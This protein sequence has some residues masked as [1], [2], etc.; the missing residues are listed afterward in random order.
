MLFFEMPHLEIE[1]MQEE[2]AQEIECAVEAFE[3][4]YGKE[5]NDEELFFFR[6]GEL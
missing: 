1:L 3:K 6:T 5:P 4:K 2:V